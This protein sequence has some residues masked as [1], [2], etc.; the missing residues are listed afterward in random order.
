MSNSPRSNP[1]LSLRLFRPS[2]KSPFNEPRASPVSAGRRP[3]AI[4]PRGGAARP[5]PSMPAKRVL[6]SPVLSWRKGS[7][8]MAALARLADT[9]GDFSDLLL[10]VGARIARIGLELVAGDHSI[11]AMHEHL[12]AR[13]QDELR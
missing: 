8:A 7:A 3:A 2:L 10:G 5:F 9:R 6:I 13:A 1:R 11:D 4:G 12:R